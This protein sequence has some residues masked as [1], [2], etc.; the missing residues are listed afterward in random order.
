MKLTYRGV[1]YKSNY[2][3]LELTQGVGDNYRGETWSQKYLRHIPVPQP[4]VDL[5][6]RSVAYCTGDP[7]DVEAAL[8]R[9]N[10][11]ATTSTAAPVTT[12]EAT[13]NSQRHQVLEELNNAHINNI[14]RSLEHRLE[15]ARAKGDRNLIRLL[16][17]EVEQIV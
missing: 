3:N 14:R 11:E 2:P 16:E 1:S 13:N 7:I 4:K 17:A 12:E 5:K 9:R 8:L 6:Y 10:Y 15:V